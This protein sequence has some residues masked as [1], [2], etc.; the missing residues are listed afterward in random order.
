MRSHLT[1]HVLRRL[2]PAASSRS[3]TSAASSSPQCLRIATPRPLFRTYPVGCRVARTPVQQRRTFLG[4]IFKK[5]PRA[6]KDVEA[7]PGYETLLRYL[8][9]RDEGTRLP[10]RTELVKA[11]RD[12]FGYKKQHERTVNST[13]AF[14]A[15]E[16]LRYL[17]VRE[18]PEQQQQEDLESSNS[19][20]MLTEED[21]CLARDSLSIS[22][23]DDPENHVEFARGLFAILRRNKMGLPTSTSLEDL[24]QQLRG[25][26]LKGRHAEVHVLRLLVAFSTFGNALEA[27]DIL[28][29]SQQH[30]RGRD[31]SL[32]RPVLHGLA[33][34]GRTQEAI[35][36]ISKFREH[37]VEFNRTMHSVITS[38]FARRDMISETKQWWFRPTKRGEPPSRSTYYQLLLF[39]LRNGEQKWATKIYEDLVDQLET[40]ALKRQ[41]ALWDVAFQWA[42]LLLGKGPEHIEHMIKVCNEK[43]AEG[44]AQPDIET[45]NRLV[46]AAIDKNDPYLAERFVVLGE[47]LGFEKNEE[48]IALQ[49]TY[50]LRANDIDGAVQAFRSLDDGTTKISHPILNEL[51][52]TLGTVTSPD[53]EKI[54]EITSHLEQRGAV[55]EPDTVVSICMAFLRNDEQYEVMDTLSLHTA[56]YSIAERGTVRKAFVQYCIDKQNST[57]RAWD[58][59]S[60]LRQFFP[61]LE[62]SDRVRI[63][64]SF[65]GRKR[66]DMACHVFGHMRAHSNPEIRP[67]VD[68]YASFFEGLGTT[69]DETSL[70]MVHNMWKMDTTTQPN[71]RLYNSLM[72]AYISCDTAYIALEFWKDITVSIEGPSYESLHLAFMAHEIMFGGDELAAELWQKIQRMEIEVPPEVYGAYV[73][74][75]AAHGNLE[76]AQTLL[77]EMQGVVG[78]RPEPITLAIIHNALQ[79]DEERD[80]FCDFAQR[81]FPPVYEALNKKYKKRETEGELK[82][83]IQRPWK[84]EPPANPSKSS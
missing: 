26:A 37:N 54:L 83:R 29:Q 7:E 66:A 32:W 52:R 44:F 25:D 21:L 46:Q 2:P 42:V 22:P 11:W 33:N 36:L 77:E 48:T 9:N 16:V 58:A 18:L 55:L 27:R 74:A 57:A 4:G 62:R 64:E 14:C 38:F 49:I 24:W 47:K 40:G 5:E 12:F 70:K 56:Y 39:A 3:A 61:E 84:I 41:K 67:T 63:M 72:V 31:P 75:I 28:L 50:R 1:R 10:L 20:E 34:E 6:L 43:V 65:F 68:E 79:S 82:Y 45:I 80:A 15:L 81:E 30:G 78:K 13:Q 69:P 71:T 76:K 19:P 59:Y 60:L 35:E 23:T 53:Y 51:I 8:A 73:A 17:E